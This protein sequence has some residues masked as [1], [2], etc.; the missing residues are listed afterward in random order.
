[1]GTLN[2]KCGTSIYL[3][4]KTHWFLVVIAL[5]INSNVLYVFT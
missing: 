5:N 3:F 4:Y 1:M 2:K